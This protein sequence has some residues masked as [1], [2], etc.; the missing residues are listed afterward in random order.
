MTHLS[1]ELTGQRTHTEREG[2]NQAAAPPRSVCVS[3]RKKR[4]IKRRN[5]EKLIFII[6]QTGDENISLQRQEPDGWGG[7]GQEVGQALYRGRGGEGRELCAAFSFTPPLKGAARAERTRTRTGEG[8]GERSS[9]HQQQGG[10][11]AAGAMKPSLLP[12]PSSPSHSP[13]TA[14]VSP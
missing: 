4:I 1:P 7:R 3:E 10:R 9:L 2:A 6:F 8:R 14:S 11:G 12:H 5:K 13:V